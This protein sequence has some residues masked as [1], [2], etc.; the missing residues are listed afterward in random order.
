MPDFAKAL[1]SLKP[2]VKDWESQ[3]ASYVLAGVSP[4]SILPAGEVHRTPLGSH[5]VIHA[6]YPEDYFHGKVRL[7]RFNSPDLKCLME[8]MREKG[9]IAERDR[10]VFLD[11]ETTGIQ[12]GAG[13]CPFLVGLGYF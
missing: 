13:M 1:R 3:L 6:V 5:Y 10:I 9:S 7:G 8:L 4:R 12:G 11:T 2:P